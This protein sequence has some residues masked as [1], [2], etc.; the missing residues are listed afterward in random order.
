MAFLDFMFGEKEKPLQL[1]LYSPGQETVMGKLRQGAEGQL[2]D[3]F[4][5]L[6]QI[7]SQDPKMMEQF[8]APAMRQFHEEIIPGIAEKFTGMGAQKSSAF[9]QA[10]GGAGAGLAERLGS[11]R[12]GLGMDA[13]GKLKELLSGGLGKQHENVMQEGTSGFLLKLLKVLSEFSPG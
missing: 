8:Q 12:A 4:Q 10:L 6:Q 1:P 7:L 5:F 11:Q 13:I 9:T 3:M 2:P